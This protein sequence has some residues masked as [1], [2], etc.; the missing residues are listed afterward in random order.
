MLNLHLPNSIVKPPM[1]ETRRHNYMGLLRPVSY[2]ASS[3]SP[4]NG[5]AKF[6]LLLYACDGSRL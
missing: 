1:H 4:L 2:W 5:L 3:Q 6:P